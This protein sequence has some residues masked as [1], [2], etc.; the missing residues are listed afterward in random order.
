MP[1]SKV[2]NFVPE[3]ESLQVSEIARSPTG[4]LTAYKNASGDPDHLS[5]AWLKTRNSFIART[6]PAYL[7]SPSRRRL[8]SLYIW[9][10]DPDS[11][12]RTGYNQTIF[13]SGRPSIFQQ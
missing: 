9:A 13:S 12:Q 6:L 8:L 7:K 1:L 4:F 5:T 2:M 10:Y 11:S 3:A